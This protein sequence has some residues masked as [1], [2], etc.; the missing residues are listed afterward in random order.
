ML[1]KPF[2]RGQREERDSD[3]GQA[4]YEADFVSFGVEQRPDG[5]RGDHQAERLSECDGPVLGWSEAEAIGEIG[6]DGAEHGGNHSVDKDGENG[7]KN[8]HSTG[9]LSMTDLRILDSVFNWC[10]MGTELTFERRKLIDPVDGQLYRPVAL[11][12]A[13]LRLCGSSRLV[14]L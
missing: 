4:E 11:A 14:G 6:Q 7:S 8:Q 2:E 13:R 3:E 5:E 1:R 12:R 10:A 9:F